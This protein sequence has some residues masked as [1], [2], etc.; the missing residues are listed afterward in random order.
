MD[1]PVAVVLAA[2]KSR[3]MNSD[4][5]KVLHEICGR[6]MIDYVLNAAHHAGVKRVV[7]VVGYKAGAVKAAL[8]QR[9]NVEFALQLKQNGTGHAVMMCESLLKD[10]RGPV[11]ILAGDTPLL[12]AES[13]MGLLEDLRKHGAAAVIGTAITDANEG[14]GRIVRDS[15]GNF[16]R[17]VEDKDADASQKSIREINTVCYAF[18]GP[19]LLDALTKIQPANKQSEYYLTDCPAELLSAGHNVI[20]SDRFDIREAIGVNTRVQLAEVHR[21]LQ[22]ECLE[23]LMLD[24]VT[25]V[26]PVQTYVDPR[27]KIGRDTIV[28]PFSTISG[29]VTI[30]TNCRIGPHASLAGPLELP[31]G[32]AVGPFTHMQPDVSD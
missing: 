21:A 27:A 9:N 12:K 25:I 23:R 5:P 18:D 24:G 11:L 31:D 4:L 26:D 3:R 30:G 10:H 19:L 32:R 2:G 15:N 17:I 14:L 6:M 1:E 7:V 13:L 8:S 29:E 28:F 22:Q 16:E 20:A